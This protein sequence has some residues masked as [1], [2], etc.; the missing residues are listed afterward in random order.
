MPVPA[1]RVVKARAFA[2]GMID[3]VITVADLAQIAKS[4]WKVVHVDCFEPGEGYAEH[5]IDGKPD[6]FWHTTWSTGRPGHPHEIQVD[7]GKP[8]SMSGFSYLPRQDMANGRIGRYEFY[9]SN[10]GK[11]WGRVV[12]TGRFRNTSA[13][14]KV[15]FDKPATARFIRLVALSEV[16]GQP[17]T[18]VAEL[19]ILPVE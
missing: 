13:L 17:Y 8:T 16:V 19:D 15:T 4:A 11:D 7:L 6:T 10:D 1:G 9:V 3:S 5:A 2:E 12:A 14:Q 18:T